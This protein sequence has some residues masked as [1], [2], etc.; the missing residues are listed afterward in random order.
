MLRRKSG[1]ADGMTESGGAGR[2]FNVAQDCY[3]INS[4]SHREDAKGAKGSSHEKGSF[5]CARRV[6]LANPSLR[7]RPAIGIRML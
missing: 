6:V 7:R 5:L 2:R 1:V 3:P 4:F